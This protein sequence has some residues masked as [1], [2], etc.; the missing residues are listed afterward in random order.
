MDDDNASRLRHQPRMATRRRANRPAT[1]F[2]VKGAEMAARSRLESAMRPWRLSLGQM[3]LIGTIERLGK[4]SAVELAR[5]L[6]LTPQAMT[7]LLRPLEDRGVISRKVDPAN[8]RRLSLS[9]SEQGLA[10][11]LDVRRAA[12]RVDREL[13]S[14]LTI[15]ELDQFRRLLAKIAQPETDA[16]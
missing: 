11:F 1:A 8:R 6:H 10:L 5:E 4:A 15:D 2:L 13:T 12:E 7:T 16:A 14:P 3:M 9:L